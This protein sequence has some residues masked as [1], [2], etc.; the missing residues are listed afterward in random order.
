[1]VHGGRA[2][3][4]DYLLKLLICAHVSTALPQ[5]KNIVSRPA[6]AAPGFPGERCPS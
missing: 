4:F 3:H 5:L 2:R 6:Q 1:M